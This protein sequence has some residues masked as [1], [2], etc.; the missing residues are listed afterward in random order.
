MPLFRGHPANRQH[1][2]DTRCKFP[3]R[4]IHH[5]AGPKDAGGF[6]DDERRLIQNAPQ[7]GVFLGGQEHQ[8]VA[9]DDVMGYGGTEKVSDL[10]ERFLGCKGIYPTA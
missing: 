7:R 1:Q 5:A 4:R 2:I 3:K 9:C 6:R 10:F 8:G